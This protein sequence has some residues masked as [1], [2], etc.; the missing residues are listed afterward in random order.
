MAGKNLPDPH[1]FYER[2]FRYFCKD[3][4]YLELQGDLDEEFYE[5]CEARGDRY[6]RKVSR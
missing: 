2:L 4:L 5:N 6:A 3:E 1:I